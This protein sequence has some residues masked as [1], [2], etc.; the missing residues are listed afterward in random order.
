MK[1]VLLI[2]VVMLCIA[3]N[4]KVFSEGTTNVEIKKE[5]SGGGM[6]VPG[7]NPTSFSAQITGN[8]MYL[9]INNYTGI[10]QVEITG[11]DGLVDTF[12]CNGSGMEVIDV[13]MLMG[14]NYTIQL[15]TDSG[16][17]Y[18]GQFEL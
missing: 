13:S 14:G 5:N 16:I 9:M 1:K 11:A 17:T 18:T 12:Y 6:R 10:L 4:V 2:S 15:I 3:S 8:L 7:P